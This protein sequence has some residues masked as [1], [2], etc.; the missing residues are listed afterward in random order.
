MESGKIPVLLDIVERGRHAPEETMLGPQQEDAGSEEPTVM[1]ESV[2]TNPPPPSDLDITAERP[3]ISQ[4][5]L[6]TYAD[7]E[8]LVDQVMLELMPQ[9]EA[10]AR[11]TIE[12]VLAESEPTD[13]S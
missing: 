12:R 6:N 3:V 11:E 13:G 10:L 1:P 4:E 7:R 9:L 5:L 8:Q 2:T